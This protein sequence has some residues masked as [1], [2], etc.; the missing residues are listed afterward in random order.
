[1]KVKGKFYLVVNDTFTQTVYI[2]ADGGTTQDPTK[3]KFFDT[4]EQA[5]IGKMQAELSIIQEVIVCRARNDIPAAF[6]PRP[7][8]S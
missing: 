4:G 1:M 3:A 7:V 6:V 8:E 5:Q 2:A